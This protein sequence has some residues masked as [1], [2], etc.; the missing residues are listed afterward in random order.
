MRI[1]IVPNTET[2]IYIALS[3]IEVV[4]ERVTFILTVAELRTGLCGVLC[5]EP[6]R[7][8]ASCE[9]DGAE[10]LVCLGVSLLGR[11][12]TPAVQDGGRAAPKSCAVVVLVLVVVFVNMPVLNEV[13]VLVIDDVLAVVIIDEDSLVDVD[14]VNGD[15][16]KVNDIVGVMV[17][18]I[19]VL[20]D[21]ALVVIATEA[22]VDVLIWVLM[23]V[24]VVVVGLAAEVAVVMAA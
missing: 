18:V 2:T 10:G 21:C 7:G 12:L 16:D 24:L 3:G 11:H 13:V 8:T 4:F 15:D 23:L 17:A 9:Y 20:V 22:D 1:S 5:E 6:E 19:D 14:V